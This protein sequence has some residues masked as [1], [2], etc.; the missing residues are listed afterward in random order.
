M[1]VYP[2]GA[3]VISGNAYEGHQAFFSALEYCDLSDAKLY[4]PPSTQVFDQAANIDL[5]AAAPGVMASSIPGLRNVPCKNMRSAVLMCPAPWNATLEREVDGYFVSVWASYPDFFPVLPLAYV[6]SDAGKNRK[7]FFHFQI[8]P[9][10]ETLR[11][12]GWLH[13][14]P[15]DLSPQTT[16]VGPSPGYVSL[17]LSEAQPTELEPST[18]CGGVRALVGQTG[19]SQFAQT[20]A[21]IT[22]P[23]SAAARNKIFYQ[24]RNEDAGGNAANFWIHT[25]VNIAAGDDDGNLFTDY[26]TRVQSA[27]IGPVAAGV[28]ISGVINDATWDAALLSGECNV[29]GNTCDNLFG[30]LY[31]A[32]GG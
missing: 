4:R 21:S 2:V 13:T 12:G 15:V 7:Q 30:T 18:R 22:R 26:H 20:L 31:T 28:T 3:S 16:L 19:A 23:Q 27:F 5:Q 1:E 25:Y 10:V 8:P 14:Q 32:I 9:G 24:A 11:V 17:F 29:V 6:M